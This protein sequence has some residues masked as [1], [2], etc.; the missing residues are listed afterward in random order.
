MVRNGSRDRRKKYSLTP[1]NPLL[2]RENCKKKRMKKNDE[3]EPVM[4]GLD[5]CRLI[6]K[7][8]TRGEKT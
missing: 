3:F 5:F 6:E 1:T 2:E 7:H 8:R 4:F